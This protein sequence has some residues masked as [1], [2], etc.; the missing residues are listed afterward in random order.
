MDSPVSRSDSS[1][2][3]GEG[4][5]CD[6]MAPLP[7]FCA[8]AAPP[9]VG[10]ASS[11]SEDEL[12]EWRNRYSFPS[13]VILRVPTAEARASSYIPGEIAVYKAFFDSGLR[14]TIPALIV[15]LSGTHPAPIEGERAVLRARQLPLDHRQVNFLVSETVLRR[16]SLWRDIS[17]GVTNDHCTAYQEAAKVMPAKKGSSSRNASGDE[18][19]ITG[20]RRSTV[21]TLEPSPSLPGKRPKSGGVTTRSAHQSAN[22][23]RS[24]ESLAVA[25]S[26][27]NSNVFPQD[28]IVLPIGDPS[29]V[30]Q[31]LQGGLLRVNSTTCPPV[32]PGGGRGPE[33]PGVRREGSACGPGVRGPRS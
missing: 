17:G 5:D 26:N 18:V 8:Y 27:L 16:S 10:P 24:A 29:E 19:M 28:G 13:S 33:A 23:A 2:E 25:L 7:L 20:S 21:V 22:M 32:S 1:S 15:G 30:V 3:P 4:S 11:V 9:L 6:L 14:G 31:V 12:A